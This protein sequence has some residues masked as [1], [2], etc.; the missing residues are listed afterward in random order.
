MTEEGASRPW[1]VYVLVVLFVLAGFAGFAANT[2]RSFQDAFMML[3]GLGV[4]YAIWIG[5]RW[6]FSVTFM[7]SSLCVA[8][9][10]A[11]LIFQLFLY[12]TGLEREVLWG[13]IFSSIIA[14]L[15]VHPASKRFASFSS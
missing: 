11:L 10:V 13:L 12:E 7:L 8:L 3:V 6:A 5:R 14:A 2:E 1:T 4:A 9:L 15:L